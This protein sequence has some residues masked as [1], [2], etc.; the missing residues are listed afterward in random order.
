MSR[1]RNG[2]PFPVWSPIH[3]KATREAARAASRQERQFL[4]DANQ[5]R[6]RIVHSGSMLPADS[7]DRVN[8]FVRQQS[9]LDGQPGKPVRFKS[10]FLSLFGEKIRAL[11]DEIGNDMQRLRETRS[12]LPKRQSSS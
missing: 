7:N 1:G 11:F 3:E 2:G 5:L 10:E 12:R 8:H 4:M 9:A 6:N